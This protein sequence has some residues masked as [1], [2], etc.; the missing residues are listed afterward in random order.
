MGYIA[1]LRQIFSEVEEMT[2]IDQIIYFQQGLRQRTQKD[3]QY[4]RG[5]TLA[6]AITV[7]LDFERAHSGGFNNHAATSSRPSGQYVSR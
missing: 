5:A 3:V 7:A 6:E 4:R 2:E 1:K